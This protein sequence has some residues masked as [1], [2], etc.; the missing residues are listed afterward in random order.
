MSVQYVNLRETNICR[1]QK[2]LIS[3]N[4]NSRTQGI[5]FD[6]R[7]HTIGN[8]QNFL[9]NNVSCLKAL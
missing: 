4:H 1:K 2:N 9:Q 7:L 3:Y 8:V 6:P 5:T